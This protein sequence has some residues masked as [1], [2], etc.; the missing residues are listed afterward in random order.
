MTAEQR[1]KASHRRL[2]TYAALS[3]VSCLLIAIEVSA[4]NA[5]GSYTPRAVMVIAAGC[6]SFV[7]LA[8][9]ILKRFAGR[10]VGPAVAPSTALA[11]SE[12]KPAW[13][14]WQVWAFLAMALLASGACTEALVRGLPEG[15][16]IL[17]VCGLVGAPL[18]W[19]TVARLVVGMAREFRQREGR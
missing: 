4:S 12:L 16:V 11:D 6:L 5:R 19:W 13:L 17:I 10:R 18:G 8:I 3:V 1:D 7:A 15:N 9:E 14:A 2:V